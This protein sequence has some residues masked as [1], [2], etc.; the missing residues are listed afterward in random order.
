MHPGEGQLRDDRSAKGQ[1]HVPLR[2]PNVALRAEKGLG[3]RP[4]PH[5]YPPLDELIAGA[6]GQADARD[7][8]E[9]PFTRLQ[10]GGAEQYFPGDHGRNEPLSKMAY[11]VVIISLQL[12]GVAQ[13]VEQRHFCISI[14]TTDKKNYGMQPD[15]LVKEAGERKPANS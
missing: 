13:P 3:G 10:R 9:Q 6:D 8:E 1:K 5:R 14:M 2:I 4:G 15:Q 7:D 11:A 12:E